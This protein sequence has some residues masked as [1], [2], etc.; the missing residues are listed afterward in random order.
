MK[1]TSLAVVVFVCGML[2]TPSLHADAV[3]VDAGWYGFC[4]GASGSPATA[5]CQN[6]GIGV[7]GNPTTFTTI[8]PVL[9]KITDAFLTGDSFTVNIN[10][11]ASIFTT[12]SVPKG[13]G[14]TTSDPDVAFAS[15]IYSHGSILLDPGS[16]SIDVFAK[17]SC[18]GGGGAYLEAV[19]ATTRVPEPAS[20]V[21]LG[22]GLVGL[23]R[24]RWKKFIS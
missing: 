16:Y 21:L 11:G 22:S 19:T 7:S 8:V 13:G 15:S 17:D 1:L 24:S 3:V 12:P 10:S 14:P 20:V 6:L 23:A 5:G 2:L 9:F 4:F 18:C